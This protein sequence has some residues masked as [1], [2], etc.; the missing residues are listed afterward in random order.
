M[1][2]PFFLGKKP[3][4]KKLSVGKPE[5]DN[6]EVHLTNVAIQKHGE[7]YNAKHGNKWSIKCLRLYLEP[8][9]MTNFDF[10]MSTL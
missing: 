10:L 6:A 1:C 8:E 5:I 4:K 9:C 3:W 7:D 2:L